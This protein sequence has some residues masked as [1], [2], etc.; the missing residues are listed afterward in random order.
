MRAR[1]LRASA[2]DA[3]RAIWQRL[4]DRRLDGYEFR[5]Q[6]PIGRYFA[7][8][9]CIEAKLI[10]ELDGGQHFEPDAMQSD[11]RRTADLNAL[12]FQVLRFNDREALVE[13][14]A[15]LL[16]ILDWL[17]IHHPHPNPLPQA[18]EGVQTEEDSQ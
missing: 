2:P 8:F 12:G 3:E 7:D 6:H 13:R 17:H 9:V 10:V 11:A 16:Q 5:R 14:D 15:V 18:G 4:R 1:G